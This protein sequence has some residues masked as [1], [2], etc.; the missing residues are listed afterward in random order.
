M[1][2]MRKLNLSDDDVT[3]L[4]SALSFLIFSGDIDVETSGVLV[5]LKQRIINSCTKR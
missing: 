1:T 5:E 3:N 4:I 2:E